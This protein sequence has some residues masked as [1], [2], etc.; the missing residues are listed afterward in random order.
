[1]VCDISRPLLARLRVLSAT[2]VTEHRIGRTSVRL[3]YLHGP[4]H[5]VAYRGDGIFFPPRS[6]AISP[7]FLEST[8]RFPNDS[9]PERREREREKEGEASADARRLGT[10]VRRPTGAQFGCQ[11]TPHPKLDS[12]SSNESAVSV[13]SPSGTGGDS[14]MQ[15]V[16]RGECGAPAPGE[17]ARRDGGIRCTWYRYLPL[18]TPSFYGA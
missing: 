8:A 15:R 12:S 16:G 18:G 6:S 3:Y 11:S 9:S 1:M 2:V 14:G 7:E 5:D 4:C 10:R 17:S 13:G